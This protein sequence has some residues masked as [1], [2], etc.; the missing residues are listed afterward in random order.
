M[1]SGRTWLSE[2]SPR[3]I[4]QAAVIAA[5]VGVV[6]LSYGAIAQS[7]GLALWQTVAMAFLVFGGAS[8]LTF[9]GVIAAGGAPLSAALGAV[10]VNARNLA[11]G[12]G[13][14]QALHKGPD[15]WFGAHFVH[16][17]S[18]AFA[19]SAALGA[20][21]PS[22]ARRQAF[23]LSGLAN[24]SAWVGTACLGQLLGSVIDADALGLDAA[25][26]VIMACLVI[27]A[28]RELPTF[29]AALLGMVL[30]L[31]LTPVLP[32]G[33]GPVSALLALIPVAVWILV[34]GRG[35]SQ[36]GDSLPS[37]ESASGGSTRTQGGT[38]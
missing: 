27:G 13:V 31:F 30:A 19:Q 2:L 11:F 16:D 3:Q 10:L 22:E 34:R 23:W 15:S 35:K 28:L 25:F 5:T 7:A 9:V 32:A 1:T 37:G 36:Q 20:R 8:E 24:G 6:G 26:P 17:E 18:A 29:A 21:A 14:G 38:S 12:L 4:R 33:L